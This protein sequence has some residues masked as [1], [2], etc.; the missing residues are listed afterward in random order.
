[1]YGDGWI[2][3]HFLFYSLPTHFENH[4]GYL[5]FNIAHSRRA[6]EV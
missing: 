3:M 1:V 4:G 5:A 2:M 6:A